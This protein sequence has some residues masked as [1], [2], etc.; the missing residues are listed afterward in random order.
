[1]RIWALGL[2]GVIALCVSCDDCKSP[3]PPPPE[4]GQRDAGTP[5]SI[6]IEIG[7]GVDIDLD[8]DRNGTIDDNA[9]DANES[10]PADFLANRGALVLV[11][12]DGDVAAPPQRDLDDTQIN[13]ASDR[14]DM[15]PLHL[16]LERDLA[17]GEHLF[18]VAANVDDNETPWLHVMDPLKAGNDQTLVGRTRREQQL[19]DLQVA[20]GETLFPGGR[21]RRYDRFLVEGLR[22]AKQVA[23]WLEIRQ[24]QQVVARDVVRIRN[25]PWLA[26]NNTQPLANLANWGIPANLVNSDGHRFARNHGTTMLRAGGRG[27]VQDTTEWGFQVRRQIPPNTSRSMIVA[28][29]LYN[30]ENDAHP[31]ER[32]L[33]ANVGVYGLGTDER[34]FQNAS[35]DQGGNLECLPPSNSHPFGRIVYGDGMSAQLRAFLERQSAQVPAVVLEISRLQLAHVDEVVAIVPTGG[36]WFAAMPDWNLARGVLAAARDVTHNVAAVEGPTY[37]DVLTWLNSDG[38]APTD[39]SYG[40]QLVALQGVM[41]AAGAT[42]LPLPG[43]FLNRR[44]GVATGGVG[45]QCSFPRNPANS[46]PT[47]PGTLVVTLPPEETTAAGVDRDSR[48]LEEWRRLLRAAGV[49]RVEPE[50]VP[51]GWWHGGEAHCVSNTIREPIIR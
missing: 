2:V 23:I 30:P 11:N 33:N 49:A 12:A 10:A 21:R 37:G 17:A 5:T 31:E 16:E 7:A 14:L 8:V 48:F 32:F 19:D 3:P 38:G 26:N 22:F 43:L 41:R 4:E 46:Q 27:F 24:G 35:G 6:P 15:S 34:Y 39:R 45:R 18:L 1:M 47:N 40:D 44:G 13:G 51:N 50:E 20:P 42:V 29:R 36:G 25:C 28:L 9:D